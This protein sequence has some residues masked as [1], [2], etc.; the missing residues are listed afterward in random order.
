MGRA[1]A[2]TGLILLLLLGGITWRVVE[3]GAQAERLDEQVQAR[4]RRIATESDATPLGTRAASQ[5]AAHPEPAPTAPSGSDAQPPALRAAPVSAKEGVYFSGELRPASEAELSFKAGGRLARILVS[6]GDWVK[7][8]Q[9]LLQLEDREAQAQLKQARAAVEA[10]KA[11]ASM[12]DDAESRVKALGEKSALSE[13]QKLTVG[14]QAR[15]AKAGQWQTEAMLELAELNLQNHTLRA[16]FA[17][18]VTRVPSGIGTMVAPGFPLMGIVDTSRWK[19]NATAALEDGGRLKIGDA[20][21]FGTAALRD[22]KVQHISP[23]LQERSRRVQF[24]LSAAPADQTVLFGGQIVTGIV[25][26]AVRK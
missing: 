18:R 10:A 8:G 6:P 2:I 9:A 11:Q 15:L 5:P 16:P 26:S 17:G 13:Q 22:G 21:E 23:T 3:R 25:K 12:A 24:E 19:V 20:V 7:E 14:D 4:M 1:G